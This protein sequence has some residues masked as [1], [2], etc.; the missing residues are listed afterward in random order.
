[1]YELSQL[2]DSDKKSLAYRIG[3]ACFEKQTLYQVC[4]VRLRIVFLNTKC[5]KYQLK[6]HLI[7]LKKSGLERLRINTQIDSHHRQLKYIA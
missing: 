2:Y 6:L 4:N 1:M 7:S 5:G 3:H